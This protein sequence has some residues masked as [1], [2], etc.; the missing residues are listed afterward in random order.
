[1]AIAPLLESWTTALEATA[2]ARALRSSIWAYPLVNAG[3]LLGVALLIGSI[4][5]FDLRLL[6]MWPWAPLVPLW[7]VLTRT[8]GVGLALAL[9]CGSMLFITRATAYAASGLFMAKMGIVVVGAV[10]AVAL[11]GLARQARQIA[12]WEVNGLPGYVRWSAGVSLAAWPSA[13]IL[14]RL[15]GYF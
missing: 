14:G 15:V 9:A 8:A 13:L 10:N 5:P 6:G 12:L 2:L 4:L 1:M 7:R 3:H 11:H